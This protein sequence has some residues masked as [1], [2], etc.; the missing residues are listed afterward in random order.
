MRPRNQW[1]C[2]LAALLILWNAQSSLVAAEE[3]TAPSPAERANAALMSKVLPEVSFQDVAFDDVIDFLRDSSGFQA[4]IVR[5]PGVPDGEP[6]IR[7]RLK[8]VPLGQLLRVIS[9]AHPEIGMEPVENPEGPAIQVIHIRATADTAAAPREGGKAVRVY[10]L[11]NEILMVLRARGELGPMGG[12]EKEAAKKGLDQ[13]LSLIK[14]VLE[15]SGDRTAPTLA[16]HEE[17]QSLIMTGTPEQHARVQDT[18]AAL[19]GE[20]PHEEQQKAL[21]RADQLLRTQK[22]DYEEQIDRLRREVD[23]LKI[24]LEAARKE[25]NKS[26]AEAREQVIAAERVRVRLEELLT[27]GDGSAKKTTTAPEQPNPSAPTA[28]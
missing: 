10:P 12:P 26:E 6:F 1:I 27:R 11:N 17:T 22:V 9:T 25:A 7:L 19:R 13:V 20:R 18:L 14:G 15:A 24:D 23:L 4:V 16:V 2:P 8:S 3:R 5:D 28:K 21:T